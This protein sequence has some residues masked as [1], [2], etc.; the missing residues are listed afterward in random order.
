MI[1]SKNKLFVRFFSHSGIMVLFKF[2]LVTVEMNQGNLYQ[3]CGVERFKI[4][5]RLLEFLRFRLRLPTPAP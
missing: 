3:G 2:A 4:R 5:L 1:F